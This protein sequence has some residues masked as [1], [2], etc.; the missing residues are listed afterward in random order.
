LIAAGIPLAEIAITWRNVAK[1]TA[2]K[3]SL[4]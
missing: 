1:F 4:R 3:S 2:I